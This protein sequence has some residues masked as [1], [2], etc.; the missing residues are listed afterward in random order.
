MKEFCAALM[1]Q[2]KD[3]E[4]IGRYGLMPLL[5][6]RSAALQSPGQYLMQLHLMQNIPFI[7][8]MPIVYR[9]R[10]TY[11]AQSERYA[12][13]HESSS[14]ISPLFTLYSIQSVPG[15]HIQHT[16][17]R[18]LPRLYIFPIECIPCQYTTHT[19]V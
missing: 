17:Y 14:L 9:F 7:N 12:T 19:I 5:L 2:A 3:V 11:Q 15:L 10:G 18:L 16:P 13:N 6:V 4:S 1:S 8:I